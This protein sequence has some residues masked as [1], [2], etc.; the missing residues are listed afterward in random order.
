LC[1][2][3][4]LLIAH[5]AD[6]VLMCARHDYSQTGQIKL[7]AD[8]L[9]GAGINVVGAVLNGA[10]ARKYAYYFRNSAAE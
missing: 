3:E 7:A 1:A 2:S 10:P 9:S 6:G 8:R 5:Q 4:T